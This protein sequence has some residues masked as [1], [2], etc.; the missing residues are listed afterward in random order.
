MSVESPKKCERGRRRTVNPCE[1]GQLT[2]G[3]KIVI[4]PEMIKNC[5]RTT[6]EEVH[7]RLFDTTLSLQGAECVSRSCLPADRND[8]LTTQEGGDFPYSD[9]LL[10]DSQ[11]YSIV[12]SGEDYAKGKVPLVTSCMPVI[13]HDPL[14]R[15]TAV[16][17]IAR[18]ME[19]KGDR[20]TTAAAFREVAF[21]LS[22]T[23][24]KLSG[25]MIVTDHSLEREDVERIREIAEK[26]G[27]IL[28]IEHRNRTVASFVVDGVS[29]NIV[30]IQ[31]P[32]HPM[33][34]A[35]MERNTRERNQHYGNPVLTRI[36]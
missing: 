26:T 8:L 23:E 33:T 12:G 18:V 11:Q 17:H 2:H 15:K 7:I 30:D 29:G 16:L 9:T 5:E 36:N 19:T 25:D 32:L 27:I 22:K 28:S 6:G 10:I 31:G 20:E 24:Q 3:D 4:T 34:L 13:I 35:I 21:R 1:Q 14:L